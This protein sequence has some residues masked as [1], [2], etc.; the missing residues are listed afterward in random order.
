MILTATAVMSVFFLGMGVLA[1]A[2]PERI[3]GPFGL[4]SL[5]LEGRNEVRAVYGGFGVAMAAVLASAAGSPAIA[6]GV[7]LTVGAAL[8]GMAGGRLVGALVERPR[9]FYPCWFYCALEAL[10]AAVLF[11]ASGVLA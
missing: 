3:L 8:A 1:L 5:T 6:P 11:A 10:G 4:P 9:S 7:F 2:A